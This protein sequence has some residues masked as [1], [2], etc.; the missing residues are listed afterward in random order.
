MNRVIAAIITNLL[1]NIYNKQQYIDGLLL[2][3]NIDI[4]RKVE[5]EKKI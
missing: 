3:M 2:Q 5:S 1:V 4:E